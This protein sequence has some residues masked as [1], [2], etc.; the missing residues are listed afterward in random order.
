MYRASQIKFK[1]LPNGHIRAFQSNTRDKRGVS[2]LQ[3]ILPQYVS[4]TITV[5]HTPKLIWI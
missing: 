5:A 2:E 3:T 4:P 1:L